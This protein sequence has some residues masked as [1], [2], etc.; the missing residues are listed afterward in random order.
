MGEAGFEGIK[1]T[2]MRRQ[3]TVAQYIAM[4]QILDLC[5]RATL[6]PGARVYRRWWEQ[7]GINLDRVKKRVAEAAA[8]SELESDSESSVDPGGEEE[9]RGASG[10]SGS[11]WS[12][13]E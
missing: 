1:N 7:A 3:N 12:G 6:R 9:S 8:V 10:L 2:V 4:Q 13:A 11:E 5:E